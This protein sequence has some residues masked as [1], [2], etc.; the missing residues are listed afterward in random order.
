[1]IMVVVVEHLEIANFP[2]STKAKYI[3]DVQKVQMEMVHGVPHK[4]IQM[5]NISRTNGL[6]VINTAKKMKVT[7]KKGV[8]IYTQAPNQGVQGVQVHLLFF[9]SRSLIVL[10]KSRIL[11]NKSRILILHPL[12]SG[13]FCANEYMPIIMYNYILYRVHTI[14]YNGRN[15]VFKI[16]TPN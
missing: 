6:D 12:F 15:R 10:N 13:P 8:Y 16:T 5:T 7:F 14:H 4:L 2:S 3:M 9:Q 1:M 11:L